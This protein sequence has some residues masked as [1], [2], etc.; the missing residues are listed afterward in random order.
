MKLLSI[1]ISAAILLSLT[2]CVKT[3]PSKNG[4]VTADAESGTVPSESGDN[5]TP[6]YDDSAVVS[7]YLNG[8]LLGL[9]EKQTEI[10]NAAVEAIGEFYLDRMSDEETVIAAHDWIVT[11]ISYDENMLLAIPKQTED[12]ENPYGALIKH[13]AI[14]MGYT[15]TFQLFMDMLGIES[16]IVHGTADDEEHAWNL[17]CLEDKWY[18]VD[19]T[20][21]D[22]VPDEENRPAFH[23]YCLVTDSVME[24]SHI[25]NK[26][27]FPEANSDDLIYYKT[28]GRYAKTADEAADMLNETYKSGVKFADI[29]YDRVT[30]SDGSISLE[31]VS[32]F[33]SYQYWLND[34]GDY[35]VIVYWML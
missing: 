9:D 23:L 11:H 1:L 16:V 17:V 2:S 13:Q 31:D 33:K 32:F 18:H 4:S 19:T 35:I 6:V 25:W 30:Q 7:A 14:C 34:F 12:S 27:A 28:H 3:E 8:E 21:D 29:M 5:L 15:T 24:V 10:Y 22:F 20:W 26:G